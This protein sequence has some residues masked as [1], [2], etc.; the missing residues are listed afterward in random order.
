MDTNPDHSGR[1]TVLDGSPMVESDLI[2]RAHADSASAFF[3]LSN[4]FAPNPEEDD[5]AN[6]FRAISIQNAVNNP[7]IFMSLHS[8]SSRNLLPPELADSSCIYL[9]K[10]NMEILAVSCFVP[11]F[12]SMLYTLSK[13]FKSE[14]DWSES[15]FVDKAEESKFSPQ[16]EFLFGSNQEI[17]VIKIHHTFVGQSFGKAAAEVYRRFNIILFGFINHMSIYFDPFKKI[18]PESRLLVI[19]S[20]REVASQFL[21][22]LESGSELDENVKEK[23]FPHV[24]G[25][26]TRESRALSNSFEGS[27]GARDQF[28]L[29][30]KFKTDSSSIDNEARISYRVV[31]SENHWSPDSHQKNKHPK[32]LDGKLSNHIVLICSSTS[33][34]GEFIMKY[35]SIES[36][37]GS[38]NS[39]DFE[40]K[41]DINPL[42]IICSNDY[43]PQDFLHVTKDFMDQVYFVKKELKNFQDFLL[44]SVHLAH[45]VK[46]QWFLVS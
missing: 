1:I 23:I 16:E 12:S 4:A 30:N 40:V 15:F 24:K 10:S 36:K 8:T 34:I 11:G 7:S 9:T 19:A 13:T 17:Y 29:K 22:S 43:N 26:I 41:F 39:E 6:I 2:Q 25:I 3:I 14:E 18:L 46:N 38:Y 45:C 31:S 27:F 44:C 35:R 33:G 28:Y 32:P 37:W 42:L 20:D 5:I 21:E